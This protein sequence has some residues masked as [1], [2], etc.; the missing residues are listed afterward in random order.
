M[1]NYINISYAII[2]FII[3]TQYIIKNNYNNKKIHIGSNTLNF[4]MSKLSDVSFSTKHI[5]NNIIH[6]ENETFD[7]I[8]RYVSIK[9]MDYYDYNEIKHT[10]DYLNEN[11]RSLVS[12]HLMAMEHN[13][14]VIL[15][16][17]LSLF[18]DKNY[19]NNI[20][21]KCNKYEQEPIEEF[22]FSE[23]VTYFAN[24]DVKYFVDK[25]LYKNNCK[26][27]KVILQWISYYNNDDLLKICDEYRKYSANKDLSFLSIHFEKN[28]YNYNAKDFRIY[29]D[30]INNDDNVQGYSEKSDLITFESKNKDIRQLILLYADLSLVVNCCNIYVVKINNNHE[31]KTEDI[32]YKFNNVVCEFGIASLLKDSCD[33]IFEFIFS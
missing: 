18:D 19:Y 4:F 30:I 27:N 8:L 7:H 23:L 24:N 20:M 14:D 3:M 17:I 12:K 26:N 28:K 6:V 31:I 32:I 2:T 15:K 25:V 33:N 29:D 10:C 21:N 5:K 1:I 9:D 16:Q 11:T 22:S 13:K